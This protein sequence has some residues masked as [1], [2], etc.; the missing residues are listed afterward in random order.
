VVINPTQIKQDAE[1]IA[2]ANTG[3]DINVP[4]AL[5]YLTAAQR[6]RNDSIGS[7]NAAMMKGRTR[8]TDAQRI[9]DTGDTVFRDFEKLD[10]GPRAKDQA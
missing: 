5:D 2:R 7:Y 9:L 4:E 6:F 3:I 8:L 1:L 10:H